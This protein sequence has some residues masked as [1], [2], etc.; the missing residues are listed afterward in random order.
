MGKIKATKETL[1]VPLPKDINKHVEKIKQLFKDEAYSRIVE[2]RHS[3]N[4]TR[5]QQYIVRELRLIFEKAKSDDLK[6]EI[7]LYDKVFRNIDR[8]AVKDELNK[9]RHNGLTGTALIRQ[10]QSVYNRHNLKEFQDKGSET[11][12]LIVKVICSEVL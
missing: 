12:P 6:S 10:L 8:K 11:E 7:N 5:A 1:G 2:Q 3:S 9:I 4:L